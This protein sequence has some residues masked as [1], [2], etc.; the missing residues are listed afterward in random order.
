[1]LPFTE[2]TVELLKGTLCAY[3]DTVLVTMVTTDRNIW[4]VFVIKPFLL[5]TL[6]N[7]L[8]VNVDTN[9]DRTDKWTI[10]RLYFMLN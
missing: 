1:M 6:I 2:M 8:L 7:I 4:I 9:A 5:I 3:C 10:D